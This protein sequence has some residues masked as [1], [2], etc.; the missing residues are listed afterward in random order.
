K[1]IARNEDARAKRVLLTEEVAE[2]M[3][4][5]QVVYKDISDQMMQQ[6]NQ[7]EAEQLQALLNKALSNKSF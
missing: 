7:Q 3:S 6:L 1:R 2:K 4:L 5:E